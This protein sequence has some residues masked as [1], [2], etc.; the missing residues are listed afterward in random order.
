V[1]FRVRH[2]GNMARIEVPATD[3]EKIASEDTR[4]EIVDRLKEL[5]FQYISL[6]LQ[7]FR[8]G[9]LNETLSEEEKKINQL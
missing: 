1:E 3:I 9:S 6:D 8:S 5:G 7:G 2:H 4:Q